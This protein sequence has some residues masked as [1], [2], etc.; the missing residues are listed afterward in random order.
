MI[1][2]VRSRKYLH[3]QSPEAKILAVASISITPKE[4][5]DDQRSPSRPGRIA[6]AAVGRQGGRRSSEKNHG[7]PRSEWND[8]PPGVGRR[9]GKEDRPG[10]HPRWLPGAPGGLAIARR[11]RHHR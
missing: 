2:G 8:G 5:T 9:C 4:I 1:S 11:D 6:D 7:R 3:M 10:P